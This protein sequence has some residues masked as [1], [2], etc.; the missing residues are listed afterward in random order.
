MIIS[1]SSYS[2]FWYAWGIKFKVIIWR[3]KLT[4]QALRH[5][6]VSCPGYLASK[7]WM[8]PR[9]HLCTHVSLNPC[10]PSPH[11]A[12]PPEVWS[13]L[14]RMHL[15]LTAWNQSSA[16]SLVTEDSDRESGP[17]SFGFPPPLKRKVIFNPPSVFCLTCRKVAHFQ[18]PCS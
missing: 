16:S 12:G 15:P 11:P 8:R 3:R 18:G 2:I 10:C 1:I 6:W 4:R 5:Q 9:P 7:W 14:E 13:I 17:L